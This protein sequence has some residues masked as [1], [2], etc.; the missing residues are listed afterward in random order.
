[1]RQFVGLRSR[2]FSSVPSQDIR[3][4]GSPK[5]SQHPS[6]KNT[7]PSQP[8]YGGSRLVLWHWAACRLSLIGAKQFSGRKIIEAKPPEPGGRSTVEVQGDTEPRIDSKRSSARMKPTE[9]LT[10]WRLVKFGETIS[11]AFNSASCTTNTGTRT[12]NF[13]MPKSSGFQVLPVSGTSKGIVRKPDKAG[14][15]LDSSAVVGACCGETLRQAISENRQTT[16][17][18]TQVAS[19]HI[20]PTRTLG[21]AWRSR[22]NASHGVDCGIT[23]RVQA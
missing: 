14:R 17:I 3:T 16:N 5:F 2:F 10:L 23:F 15:R 18:G 19:H 12:G 4:S 8:F 22:R 1:V 13:Q 9:R 7:Q 11:L 21:V 20:C 6:Q